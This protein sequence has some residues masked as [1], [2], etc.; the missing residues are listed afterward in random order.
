MSQ[1]G[2]TSCLGEQY[3]VFNWNKYV[4]KVF[5]KTYQTEED[6][7]FIKEWSKKDWYIEYAVK[8]H[9]KM[10]LMTKEG[11][12]RPRE[13]EYAGIVLDVVKELT[14]LVK[15]HIVDKNLIKNFIEQYFRKQKLPHSIIGISLTSDRVEGVLSL[16]KSIYK[17]RKEEDIIEGMFK[18]GK[19][20][21]DT[22]MLRK[23]SII[24]TRETLMKG[25]DNQIKELEHYREV[26]AKYHQYIE[27]E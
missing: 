19:I 20:N 21:E 22:A 6:K 16:W 27:N 14:P 26:N 17:L 18:R 23:Q 11:I 10:D 2:S 12:F 7:K 8:K 13:L 4:K 9:E 1:L 25:I 15:I 24:E 5:Y 3:T